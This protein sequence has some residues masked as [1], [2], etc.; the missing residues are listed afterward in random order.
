MIHLSPKGLIASTAQKGHS[1]QMIDGEALF[2]AGQ[3]ATHIYLV[4][5]GSLQVF[6][7]RSAIPLRRYDQ[8]EL[9]GIPEV[10]A[11][12]A[13]P[14]TALARGKTQIRIFPAECLTDR[15]AEIPENSVSFLRHLSQLCD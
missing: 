2:L 12:K 13:W 7:P 4:E 5:I 6:A 14:V 1:L 15:M 9:I 8:H 11:G 10:M 3:M